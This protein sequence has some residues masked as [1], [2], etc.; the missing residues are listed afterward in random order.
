MDIMAWLCSGLHC[1]F[2]GVGGSAGL[3]VR[4]I[5]VVVDIYASSAVLFAT[6]KGAYDMSLNSVPL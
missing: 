4:R 5:L 1:W 6:A 3:I 2:R